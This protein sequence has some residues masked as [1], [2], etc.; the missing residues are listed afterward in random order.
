LTEMLAQAY[1][2]AGAQ[3]LGHEFNSHIRGTYS[4]IIRYRPDLS[5]NAP[6]E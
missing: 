5:Y 1:G 6:A 3:A 2:K 4:E